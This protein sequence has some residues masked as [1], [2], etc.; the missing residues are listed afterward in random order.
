MV[1]NLEPNGGGNGQKPKLF[2]T[3]YVY[4]LSLALLLGPPDLVVEF[5]VVKPQAA[6]HRKHFER[7]FVIL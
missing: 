1:P 2:Q 4:A 3:S 6:V 5:G 7:V